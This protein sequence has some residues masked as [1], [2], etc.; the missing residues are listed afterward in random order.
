MRKA[1]IDRKGSRYIVKSGTITPFGFVGI[2][3]LDTF[4]SLKDAEK[5]ADISNYIFGRLEK[6]MQ[7]RQR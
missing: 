3:K 5:K 7:G 1:W 6:Y 4:Y 2:K